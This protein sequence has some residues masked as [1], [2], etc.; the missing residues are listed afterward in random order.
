V[1]TA[2]TF[3]E[4]DMSGCIVTLR[5]CSG[6]TPLKQEQ[7]ALRVGNWPWR[8]SG[9]DMCAFFE[10]HNVVPDSAKF[11]NNEE[12]RRSGQCAV[13]FMTEDDAEKA[14]TDLNGQDLGGR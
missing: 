3:D 11:H 1:N 2:L 8:I 13:L 10:S 5:R 9:E 6:D 7:G 4:K 12:G 14:Y